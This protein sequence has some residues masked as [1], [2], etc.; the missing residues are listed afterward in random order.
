MGGR[1][2]NDRVL[3]GAAKG[4]FATLV[5]PPECNAAFGKMHHTLA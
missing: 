2:T 3:H 1:R 4:S 5:S